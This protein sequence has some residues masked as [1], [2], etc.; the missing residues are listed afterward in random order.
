MASEVGHEATA[1]PCW[2]AVPVR[3]FLV[4]NWP[5]KGS[6]QQCKLML[7]REGIRILAENHTDLTL[8]DVWDWAVKNGVA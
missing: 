2:V 7:T 8:E 4:T 1:R 3:R 5:L 6:R